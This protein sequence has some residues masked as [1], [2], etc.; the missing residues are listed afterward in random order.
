MDR[1]KKTSEETKDEN[2]EPEVLEE[3][4][5]ENQSEETKAEE[6]ESEQ[7]VENES[8]SDDSQADENGEGTEEKPAETAENAQNEKISTE[9]EQVAESDDVEKIKAEN[10]RLKAQL[11]AHAA[12]FRNNVIEDAVLI[13]SNIAQRD[14]IEIAE[15]L[16]A[17]AKKYPDWK[18]GDKN[19]QDKGSGFKVG[20]DTPKQE[21]ADDNRLNDAFGIRKKK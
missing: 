2:K 11:E 8:A 3:E 14:G 10:I 1:K 13:A 17:V 9:T 21:N 12:G 18:V 6:S 16:G 20:A 15:A 19:S 4:K 7:T 5:S